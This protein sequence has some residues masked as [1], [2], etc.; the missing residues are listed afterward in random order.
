MLK[1]A[2]QPFLIDDF[3]MGLDWTSP[4]AK[5]GPRWLVNAKNVN[6]TSLKVPE[7]RK[8]YSA[9]YPT[10]YDGTAI[11]SLYEYAA[12]DGNNYFLVATQD[13]I[14]YYSAGWNNLKTD[15]EDSVRYSFAQTNGYCFITNGVDAMFK[16]KNT[17]VYTTIGITAPSVT[18]TVTLGAVTYTEQE[19]SYT[20]SVANYYALRDTATAT[21]I[22]QTIQLP[23]NGV[24]TG[25]TIWCRA[26]TTPPT[27]NIWL[28]IW[29]NDNGKPGT[30]IGV[31][32]AILDAST[33]STSGAAYEFTFDNMPA[34]SSGAIYW[35]LA[36]G[37]YTINN[38][39]YIRIGRATT[40]TY[41][42]GCG[43]RLNASDVVTY[44]GPDLYLILTYNIPSASA[45]SGRYKWVYAYKTA[46]GLISN[47]STP[48][49]VHILQSQAATVTCTY[50]TNT[51]VE[52]IVLY[53]TF[54]MGPDEDPENITSYYKVSETAN[55]S[56]GSPTTVGIV[57]SSTDNDLTTLAENNNTAPPLAKYLTVFQDRLIYAN[58]PGETDGGSLFMMSKVGA[59]ES[60]PSSNYHYFDRDDGNDITGITML[61]DYLIVFKKNKIAA[62]TADFSEWTTISHGIGCIA[63]WAIITLTDKVIFLSEE[64]VKCTDGRTVYDIGKKLGALQR[65][66]F[67]SYNNKENYTAVYYPDK[68]HFLINMSD[69]ESSDVTSFILVGHWLASLYMDITPEFAQADNYVGWTYHQYTHNTEVGYSGTITN[70]FQTLGTFTDSNGITRVAAGSLDGYVYQLD[71]GLADGDDA[72]TAIEMIIETG[73]YD[74]GIPVSITKTIRSIN[75][76]YAGGSAGNVKLYCDV[77]FTRNTSYSTLAGSGTNMDSTYPYITTLF[78]GFGKMKTENFNIDE[79]ACGKLF[80]FRVQNNGPTEDGF[81]LLSIQPFFRIEGIR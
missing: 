6:L 1:A 77:D 79:T 17:T 22:A 55:D 78:A 45:L 75:V 25:I 72:A 62:M 3:S 21:T 31:D 47:Y 49:D 23:Y 37:D 7:K 53:R 73:W 63:P 19:D 76:T 20:F 68:R 43:Y 51:E 18:P 12:P 24:F 80:S 32:S 4:P 54:D 10:A 48:S 5:V 13:A 64:G 60:V 38:T 11:A 30:Q 29:T 66:G 28:E 39:N 56:D 16:L 57:D 41:P 58:C 36:K 35:I 34:L 59:P 61:P 71:Y 69:V 42:Y 14:G 44:L 40:S 81:T 2:G 65:S 74:L 67:F 26:T 50:S 52:Y 27:G 70:N 8:G 33:I 15:L 9:L 46:S